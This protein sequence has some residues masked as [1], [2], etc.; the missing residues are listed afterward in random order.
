MP[1]E[2]GDLPPLPSP[3]RLRELMFDA[4]RLGRTDVLPAL[5]H[6]GCAVEAK[7]ERGYTPL[8]LAAYHGQDE[9]V[10]LLLDHGADPEAGDAA[11]GNTALMGA[12]FKGFTSVARLLLERGAEAETTNKAGQTA[13]MLAALFDRREIADL[14]LAQGADPERCDAAGNS[15]LSV[16]RDQNNAGMAEHLRGACPASR[17]GS[18]RAESALLTS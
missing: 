7:D 8:I 6:A 10:A 2:A 5:L 4:A 17:P 14:L 11:R 9:A 12:A 18:R 3:E 1:N 13:L 15:A 16:A